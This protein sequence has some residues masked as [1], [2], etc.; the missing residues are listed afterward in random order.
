MTWI[1]SA[2]RSRL[3]G[4]AFVLIAGCGFGENAQP[5]DPT[6]SIKAL[7]SVLDAWKAGEKPEDLE[8]LTPPIHV[9]DADWKGGFFLVSYKADQEGRLVGYDMNY[10]VVLELKDPRGKPV[11][12]TAVYSI[13][14]RPSLLVARQE[15]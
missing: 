4:C 11:K 7:Q 12:K 3:T 13:T 9:K 10:P 1:A 2:L 6:Q 5:A 14:T 8:K 15:G